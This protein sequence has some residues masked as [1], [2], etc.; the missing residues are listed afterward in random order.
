MVLRRMC[1]PPFE[2]KKASRK[3]G[4]VGDFS[5]QWVIKTWKMVGSIPHD[6]SKCNPIVHTCKYFI[7]FGHIN[8]CLFKLW[9]TEVTYFCT[10]EL[11]SLHFCEV[12]LNLILFFVDVVVLI[13]I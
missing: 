12:P 11:V 6:V 10:Y 5:V 7:F 1:W 13:R 8:L 3:R 4:A 9:K 2:A